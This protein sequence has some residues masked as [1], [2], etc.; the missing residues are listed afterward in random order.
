MLSIK[1]I[2]GIEFIFL[3]VFNYGIEKILWI[4]MKKIKKNG[5]E[6]PFSIKCTYRLKMAIVAS[7]LN[8]FILLM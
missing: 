6:I 7:V 2:I 3:L 5:K 1:I 4:L 8:L